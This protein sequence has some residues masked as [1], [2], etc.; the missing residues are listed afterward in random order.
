MSP[1]GSILRNDHWS[2]IT[3]KSNLK[4]NLD[5]DIS[6]ST[7]TLI[8]HMFTCE[9][10]SL[11]CILVQLGSPCRSPT[12]QQ[13]LIPL[14]FFLLCWFFSL[15]RT[16]YV[17]VAFLVEKLVRPD[18]DHLARPLSEVSNNSCLTAVMNDFI[19]FQHIKFGSPIVSALCLLSLC[20]QSVGLPRHTG[21]TRNR[22]N[23]R[24]CVCVRVARV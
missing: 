16:V 24:A 2:S 19:D 14:L 1:R 9:V 7:L 15:G 8:T 18:V 3:S 6:E 12:R 5:C 17:L 22:W 21:V 23:V 13:R 20:H 11:R 10:S 4:P